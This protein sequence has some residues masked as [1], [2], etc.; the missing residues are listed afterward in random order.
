[1]PGNKL[2]A[3]TIPVYKK[4]P[5]PFEELALQQCMKVLGNY[6]IIFF[7]PV[8]LDISFYEAKTSGKAQVE[9]FDDAFFRDIMG[10]NKLMLSIEFY[11]RFEAYEYLLIYQL[12]AFIF[13]DDL[14]EWCMKGY[15]YV[16]APWIGWEWST[17]YSRSLTFPRRVLYKLGFR[18]FNMVGNGGFSLRKIKPAINN[19]KL[20]RKSVARFKQNEDYFFSFFINSYNPFFRVAPFKEALN[21]A[22]DE[23]PKLAFEKNNGKLPMA[24]HAWMRYPEFWN[25]FVRP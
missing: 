23:N 21:F 10:Y 1:M 4:I 14:K 7:A 12:D 9:R 13:K 24:C 20:F 11:K 8:S 17:W 3:I 2:V 5:E 15:D 22:F 6:Q 18:K 16:G 19:L 25:P